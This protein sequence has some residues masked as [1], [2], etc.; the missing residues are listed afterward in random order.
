M[1]SFLQRSKTAPLSLQNS[2]E[3]RPTLPRSLSHEHL[4]SKAKNTQAEQQDGGARI[5]AERRKTTAGD[6]QE[7]PLNRGPGAFWTGP[8]DEE[9]SWMKEQSKQADVELSEETVEDVIRNEDKLGVL[10]VGGLFKY[11][12]ADDHLISPYSD[13]DAVDMDS[14]YLHL[15]SQ[16]AK[17]PR[18]DAV[19]LPQTG[20]FSQLFLVN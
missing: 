5:W 10:S 7:D 18:F 16:R 6:E 15:R 1:A 11:W 13:E 8:S 17:V 20:K 12:S 2:L 19:E 4:A 9:W 3:V 14:L